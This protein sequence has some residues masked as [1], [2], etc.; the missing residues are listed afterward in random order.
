MPS[1]RP[2][3]SRAAWPQSEYSQSIQQVAGRSADATANIAEV[4]RAADETGA[5][6]ENVLSAAQSLSKESSHLKVEVDKFLT[7]VAAA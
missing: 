2:S 7:T 5:A 3:S 4:S 6:S 1:R